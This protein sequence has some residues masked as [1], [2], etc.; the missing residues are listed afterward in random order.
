M[1]KIG[2]CLSSMLIHNVM[3]ASVFVIR[4][5]EDM[6][7]RIML[8]I[9]IICIVIGIISTIGIVSNDDSENNKA[10]TGKYIRVIT[11]ENIT[12]KKYIINFVLIMLSAITISLNMDWRFLT[13]FW[14]IELLYSIPYA[15]S[16]AIDNNP[17]LLMLG[18]NVFKCSCENIFTEKAEDYR[19][20]VK[21]PYIE[22]GATIKL[23]NISNHTLKLKDV[24][25]MK[26][27][28][29]I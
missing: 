26:Q 27:E 6:G 18:Y 28:S 8:A 22:N 10:T 13:L 4:A 2:Y 7:A 21:K 14:V 5:Y 17:I 24:A 1:E 16:E 29:S 25:K 20:L 3:F 12:Q 15:N 19:F 23:K 9:F 11:S